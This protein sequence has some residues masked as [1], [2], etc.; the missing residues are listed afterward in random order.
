MAA[1][2]AA[3]AQLIAPFTG[4]LSGHLGVAAS[5]DVRGAAPVVGASMLVVDDSGIGVEV[6]AGHN[7]DFNDQRFSDSSI[8]TVTLNLVYLYPHDLLRP[9]ISGGAG[10]VRLRAAFPGQASAQTQTDTSWSVGGGVLYMWNEALGLRGELRYF[11]Q[12]GRQ[13]TLPLGA[14]GA[15]NFIRSSIGVTYSWPLR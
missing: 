13:N 2:T 9:F 11:R 12:F 4:V 1:A 14:N 8:T 15:L 7:S 5:G 3:E 10:V 6:D